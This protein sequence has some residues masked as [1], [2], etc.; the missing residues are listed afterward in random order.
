MP[1]YRVTAVRTEY[2]LIDTV[3]RAESPEGAESML[4][5]SPDEQDS[6]TVTWDEDWGGSD[7]EVESIEL[8]P[9]DHDPR[10][11]DRDRTLCSYCGRPAF[12]SG[13][14][15]DRS[16]T[17]LTIPGPRLHVVRPLVSEGLGL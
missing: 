2:H 3:V 8:F 13:T 16:P 9:A 15:A 7:T 5:R 6:S 4:Y 17:G 11:S 10:L 14:P 12:W 1:L